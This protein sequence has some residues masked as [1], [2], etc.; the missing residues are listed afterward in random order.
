M[1]RYNYPEFK[2]NIMNVHILLALNSYFVFAFKLIQV[3]VLTLLYSNSI[4]VSQE[5]IAHRMLTYNYPELKNNIINFYTSLALNSC[6][7][8]FLF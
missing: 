4:L 1:L 5:S 6:L 3:V 8:L 2:N 7:S